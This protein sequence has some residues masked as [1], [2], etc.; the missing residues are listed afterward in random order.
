MEALFDWLGRQLSRL[1]DAVISVYSVFWA[2][3]LAWTYVVWK[4][5][6]L[7]TGMITTA[8]THSSDIIAYLHGQS[9]PSAPAGL[10]T[11]LQLSNTFFPL[12]ELF[13]LTAAY[14]SLV[15]L[16]IGVY[17]FIKSWIPALAGGS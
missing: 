10:A 1:W 16:P 3:L 12:D 17:R 7:V 4:G 6:T 9:S 15:M 11:V 2:L 13:Q 8:L 5:L 14:I